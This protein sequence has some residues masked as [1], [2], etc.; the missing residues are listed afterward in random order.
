MLSELYGEAQHQM[1]KAST[2]AVD[3]RNI[4]ESKV[5]V[6][7]GG[8]ASAD[9][10]LFSSSACSTQKNDNNSQLLAS[11]CIQLKA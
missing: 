11:S 7:A 1:S 9:C 5:S 6:P 10:L 3:S 8:Y 4:Q 2:A